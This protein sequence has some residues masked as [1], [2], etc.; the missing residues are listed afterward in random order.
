M[1]AGHE[2]PDLRGRAA[3]GRVRRAAVSRREPRRLRLRAPPAQLRRL[4]LLDPG[5]AGAGA[6]LARPARRGDLRGQEQVPGRH[7]QRAE[8]EE[9]GLRGE[10]QEAGQV[11]HGQV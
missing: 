11:R 7:Q 8:A 9:R 6:V 5:L 3:P 2:E 4:H 10:P 1:S